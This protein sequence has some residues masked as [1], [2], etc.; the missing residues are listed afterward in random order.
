M[1]HSNLSKEEVNVV[2]VFNGMKEMG[3][4]KIKEKRTSWRTYAWL[5]RPIL[6]Q[7]LLNSPDVGVACWTTWHPNRTMNKR[8]G[9]I[10]I[11]IIGPYLIFFQEQEKHAFCF[12]SLKKWAPAFKRLEN[13]KLKSRTLGQLT[14]QPEILTGKLNRKYPDSDVGFIACSS[15]TCTHT[16][17]PQ[18]MAL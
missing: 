18:S 16:P 7:A 2:S 10:V 1:F 12:D 6:W 15:S 14:Q 5:N 4:W 8:S 17:L 11:Q 3:F 13:T 9:F